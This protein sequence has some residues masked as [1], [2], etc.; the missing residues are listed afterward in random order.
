METSGVSPWLL[1]NC[2][3]GA[4]KGRWSFLSLSRELLRMG[5]GVTFGEE[6]K[7]TN[8]GVYY[9]MTCDTLPPEWDISCG[10]TP[11]LAAQNIA[12]SHVRSCL[13]LVFWGMLELSAGSFQ[14]VWGRVAW[15]A[16]QQCPRRGH[17]CCAVT[18]PTCL[19]TRK[20]L[21]RTR[22]LRLLMGIFLVPDFFTLPKSGSSSLLSVLTGSCSQDEGG[23]VWKTILSLAFLSQ[24]TLRQ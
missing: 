10:V 2:P 24:I 23:V 17:R 9:K 4:G 19:K 18:A 5:V 6:V 15:P 7:L 13:L 11:G 21:T 20:A 3:R 22:A 8:V 16:G 14:T 1:W 12:T